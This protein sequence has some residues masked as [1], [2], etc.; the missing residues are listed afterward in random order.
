[1][2]KILLLLS[3]ICWV[4][5]AN[6]L[7]A[8]AKK[9]PLIEHFTQASCGPCAV[10]NPGFQAL[11][12]KNGD[13]AHHLAIHTWWPGI[14]PMW[15]HNETE[16]RA[17]VDY[18]AVNAVPDLQFDGT[19]VGLPGAV[20]QSMFDNA[21]TSPI[22]IGVSDVKT[23]TD[24]TTTVTIKVLG[25]VPAGTYKMRVAAVEYLITYANPPGS[26]GEKEFPNVFR[27]FVAN[28]SDGESL[29]LVQGQTYTYSY[30]YPID[31]RWKADQ[32]YT[33]AWVF[34]SNNKAI[35]NSGAA[36]DSSTKANLTSKRLQSGS[37]GVATQ[38]SGV[39]QNPTSNNLEIRIKLNATQPAGWV[40]KYTFQGNEY[41]GE[42]TFTIAPGDH[43]VGLKV[44]SDNTPAV[45]EYVI[46]IFETGKV[47]AK[48]EIKSWVIANVSDLVTYRTNNQVDIQKQCTNGLA[49]AGN[50]KNAPL[51]DA[52]LAEG[53]TDG[54][55]NGVKNIY[56]SVGLNGSNEVFSDALANALKAF[57][58]RGGNLFITGQDIGYDI[59]SN[60]ANSHPSAAKNDFFTNYLKAKY[61]DNG[62]ST[63]NRVLSIISE[64][65]FGLS[66]ATAITAPYGSA[67]SKPDKI[68]P[69]SGAVSIFTY[70]R[71]ED[72]A[73]V[74][75]QTSKYKVVYMAVGIEQLS[76]SAIAN[77]ILKTSH[78]WFY[79]L[80]T[81]TEFDEAM[82][83]LQMGQNF[84]NPAAEFTVIPFD[85]TWKND[86]QL[87]LVDLNGRILT[88]EKV[89][90]GST[91][92]R[93][94]TAKLA[95]G[96][97]F[98]RLTDGENSGTPMK[99]VVNR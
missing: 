86:L 26:N 10:Q 25:N 52:L 39:I 98:Y 75:A 74:R 82:A 14:D 87:Q 57:L 35:L 6:P 96:V 85:G 9:Y 23:A 95:N 42:N 67:N 47:L 32:I 29:N 51:P 15:N 40:A 99:L 93:L 90:A 97:Y 71:P 4:A 13:H 62:T 33:M 19:N 63:R 36:Y 31:S 92:I 55:L 53:L 72:V 66:G 30:T 41:T 44:T 58:D 7:N 12:F 16:N 77:V 78:D 59:M 34:N 68:E 61:V 3:L 79:G 17:M 28:G 88:T 46:D 2:K 54:T 22:E 76:N 21:T 43:T 37:P 91:S 8:Q 5:S 60:A 27:K 38:F 83:A 94:N 56:Y 64:P 65:L 48:N 50:S 70:N 84:P 81:S 69:L 45:G 24:V 18:Y 11:F 49:F 80:I 1:M 20:T 73:G 89:A